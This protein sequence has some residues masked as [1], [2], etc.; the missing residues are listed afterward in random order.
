LNTPKLLHNLTKWLRSQLPD[1]DFKDLLPLGFEG[2]NGGIVIGNPATPNVLVAEFSRVDGMFGTVPVCRFAMSCVPP[3]HSLVQ[4]FQ[5]KSPLDLCKQLLN[6][7]FE[8]ATINLK[9]NDQY[10][11]PM[12]DIGSHLHEHLHKDQQVSSL[13]LLN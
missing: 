6:I 1:L 7:K 9:E 5:S 4:L 2:L 10:Q 8:N 3:S 11:A 12:V 13:P